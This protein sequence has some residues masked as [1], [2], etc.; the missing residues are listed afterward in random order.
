MTSSMGGVGDSTSIWGAASDAWHMTGLAGGKDALRVDAMQGGGAGSMPKSGELAGHTL[1]GSFVHSEPLVLAAGAT[2]YGD[3]G[4]N[5]LL[6]G[7]DDDQLYGGLGDDLL[8]GEVGGGAGADALYGSLGDALFM[9]EVGAG[10]EAGADALYGGLGDDIIVHDA[11]NGGRDGSE[12]QLQQQGSRAGTGNTG[13]SG[14][15][16]RAV[17]TDASNTAVAV[18]H[19][20]TTA[21]IG[22]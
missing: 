21:S 2:L 18:L 1:T 13:S 11:G 7:A 15:E 9:G 5:M 22:K 16:T 10:V 8:M 19:T 20:Q 17:C 12:G 6:G 3:A 14:N 4:V